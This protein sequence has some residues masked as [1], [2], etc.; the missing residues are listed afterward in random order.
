MEIKS[1]KMFERNIE[2]MEGEEVKEIKFY[3]LISDNN[4]NNYLW[5]A[6]TFNNVFSS[7]IPIKAYNKE[8]TIYIN[9]EV[10]EKEDIIYSIMDNIY[11][12]QV[13]IN[14]YNMI[15]NMIEDFINNY[16]NK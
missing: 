12:P 3:L 2:N 10:L 1:F 6:T 7:C 15:Y 14:T 8:V 4:N 9:D 13:Y 5:R 11:N 16:N